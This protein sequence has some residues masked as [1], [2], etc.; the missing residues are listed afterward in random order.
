MEGVAKVQWG[1]GRNRGTF[2]WLENTV[3][4]ELT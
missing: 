4:R 2:G 1:K 3:N